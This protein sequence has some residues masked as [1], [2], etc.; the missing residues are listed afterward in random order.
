MKLRHAA[1]LA[2][3]G[4]YLM[5]PPDQ[6]SNLK[7]GAP[8]FFVPAILARAP[9]FE[10]SFAYPQDHF[11]REQDCESALARRRQNATQDARRDGSILIRD[12][13]QFK[14]EQLRLARC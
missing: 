5:M 1:A 14:S 12:Q 11:E 4:W 3:V 6:N 9:L 2:L 13:L 10:W 7:P 8:R